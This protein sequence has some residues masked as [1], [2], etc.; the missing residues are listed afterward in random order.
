MLIH[1]IHAPAPRQWLECHIELPEG[2]TVAAALQ[3]SGWW[4]R[5][6]LA[7]RTDMGLA[8]WNQRVHLDTVLRDQDRIELCRDLL[9]DPKVA[10]RERF[11]RQGSRASGLFAQRRPG[12]KAGY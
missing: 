9:I 10:R 6:A 2:S 5:F 4:D 1:L 11:K 7:G 8:V 3:V 12:A